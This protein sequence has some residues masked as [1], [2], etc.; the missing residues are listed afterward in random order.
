MVT[1]VILVEVGAGV[2]G[3]SV[4]AVQP[5]RPLRHLGALLRGQGGRALGPRVH[6]LVLLRPER[7]HLLGIFRR[8]A[9]QLLAVAGIPVRLAD[10]EAWSR[11]YGGSHSGT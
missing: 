9:G 7:R 4:V 2:E 8:E 1:P 3:G 11:Y 10:A 6:L 5:L